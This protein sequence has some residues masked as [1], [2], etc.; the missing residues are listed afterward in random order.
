[1][2]PV[3]LNLNPV[4][5]WVTFIY[6]SDCSLSSLSNRLSVSW[7]IFPCKP[8]TAALWET[9]RNFVNPFWDY[10]RHVKLLGKQYSFKG[11]LTNKR[12]L[13]WSF[14][15]NS[16][17]G[18]GVEKVQCGDFLVWREQ[19]V[20]GGR[21]FATKYRRLSMICLQICSLDKNC[22]W[23]LP[24]DKL[25]LGCLTVEH[26]QVLHCQELCWPCRAPGGCVP[27]PVE[28]SG[29]GLL[30]A[31]LL[32]VC[33][34]GGVKGNASS[35]SSSSWVLCCEAFFG[36]RRRRDAAGEQ[37]CFFTLALVRS[38]AGGSILPLRVEWN[39]VQVSG[40]RGVS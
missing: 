3:L 7:V 20:V 22:V 21:E 33:W 27:V 23:G 37:Q 13:L 2:V 32:L 17:E 26:P 28:R 9:E 15:G 16:C 10:E 8:V 29:C 12:H 24:R 35:S 40:R 1:M 34:G 5:P 36:T 38:P 6:E 4:F 14:W 19:G 31:A 11:C 39:A 25:F 30:Q 18:E